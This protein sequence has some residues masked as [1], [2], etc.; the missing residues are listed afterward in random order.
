[1][2]ML[3]GDL[4][5]CLFYFGVRA[6]NL[7]S[8]CK[9]LMAAVIC[10]GIAAASAPA[11]G[12]A[13]KTELKKT[14]G[15]WQLLRDGKPFF[16]KGA[17][18]DESRDTL[19]QCG[20]N[21]FRTWG[22]GPETKD[23]LDQAQKLG[24]AVSVGYWLG[25][26]EH[27]FN[28]DNAAAVKEQFDGAKRAVLA[29]KDHPAVL[30]WGVGNEMENG[31]TGPA[32]Y[33]AIQDIAHMIKQIDPNHPTMTVI[34][35]IGSDKVKMINEYCPDI[36]IIGINSYGAGPSLVE[37]YRK[38]GGYKPY[39]ITE[40]GPP[41][42]WEIPMNSWGA[43]PEMTST[44][45]ADYY[46]LTYDK[47][48]LGAPDLCLGSYVFAWGHKR[49]ATATWFGLFLPDGSR[50]AAVDTMQELWSGKKPA[51]PC[52]SMNSLT[53]SG[54]DV[55][56]GG[57]T[58]RATVSA[59]DAAG[60]PV[61]IEWALY[62]EMDT[63]DV[64]GANA[65]PTASFPD[66]IV[67]NGK[68]TV[69]IKLPKYG[70]IYRIYCYVRND[71][72]AAV[73]SI[74]LKVN[75]PEAPFKAA[76]AALPL[77]IFGDGATGSPYIPSGWMGNVGGISM[78]MDSTD[79]PHSKK[80]CIKFTYKDAGNWGGVVWQSPAN[81]WGDKAG[82][83]NLTGAKKLTFWARGAK[84]GEKIKFG[85]GL[86]T[87]KKYSDTGKGETSV[88]EL[89]PNWK[90]YSIDLNGVDLQCIKSGFYWTLGGQGAPVTFFLDD[91]KYE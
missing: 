48:V 37:R 59:S 73:G 40:F 27:G 69:T 67:E 19:V 4:V 13:I 54:K 45:K 34:A 38:Q 64:Q 81:D 86:I 36:D 50:L 84:G 6:V 5:V 1:M 31:Y 24:L 71:A 90:Q 26:K 12:Q 83:F 55:L 18:G 21:S 15:G 66:A 75:G 57:E 25:H 43:A 22:V 30:I 88:V 52:P 91:M 20:G 35:E 78:Q 47:A 28:Y 87:G 2:N 23:Q 16:V 49:E 63:Y 70:G 51:H 41:G 58:V 39:I 89:T 61:K 44:K 10:A 17:G 80:A 53:L 9:W 11:Q 79:N 3:G 76:R 68:P 56:N 42:T 14:P 77:V 85:F 7:I 33:K 72:G 82:G 60:K 62:S 46:R 74:P 65:D 32:V 8:S 29:Y